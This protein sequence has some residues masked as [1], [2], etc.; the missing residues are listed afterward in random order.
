M[1]SLPRALRF[2]TGALGGL[3][4]F[5]HAGVP[6]LARAIEP[7]L[8]AIRTSGDVTRLPAAAQPMAIA[9]RLRLEGIPVPDQVSAADLSS[10]RKLAVALYQSAPPSML[11]KLEA[12][13]GRTSRPASAP[14]PVVDLPLASRAAQRY[15][16]GPRD[17][18]LVS[19]FTQ[20]QFSFERT[21]EGT[22]DSAI[23]IAV[24]E[25]GFINVPLVGK[26]R[27]QGRT[28]DQ[29]EGDITRQLKRYVKDPQ[30]SVAIDTFKA[31][32]VY[33][34]GQVTK[35]GPI[36]LEHEGTTLFEV[37]SRAGGFINS[38][39][40]PLEGADARHVFVQRGN[41]KTSVDFY[42]AATD[43][44]VAKTFVVQDGDMVFVPKPLHRVQ[45]LGGVQSSG[46][47]EYKP[48]MTLM[49]AVAK[50]G[51]FTEKSRRDQVRVI[52]ETGREGEQDVIPL[53]ATR[54]FKGRKDDF[55]LQPGDI[56]YVNE[57]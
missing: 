41:T 15:L 1:R 7:T 9:S 25:S 36:Y 8:K 6:E 2:L 45:V 47:F 51:S 5:C 22:Q 31:K 49:E 21:V 53:D 28:T 30:V 42:G 23:P 38:F 40:N 16:L 43:K 46:E 39:A 54:I 18:L 48:G 10:A 57:W 50:A 20:D 12:K 35:N 52:R 44:K 27:A 56:V 26:I 29:V 37:I 11:A 55:V 13:G 4:S 34:V 32:K 19:I 3:L 24:N 17:I 33:V 14:A